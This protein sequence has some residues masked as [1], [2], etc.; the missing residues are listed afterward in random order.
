[1][2]S[3]LVNSI[4]DN[5]HELLE[6][7]KQN[8]GKFAIW[9]SRVIQSTLIFTGLLAVLLLAFS[10]IQSGNGIGK[11]IMAGMVLLMILGCTGLALG[12]ILPDRIRANLFCILLYLMG[13]ASLLYYGQVG[14]GQVL[15]FMLPLIAV[16]L[17][18]VESSLTFL[19][20]SVLT[21]LGF[22]FLA[23][24][25]VLDV[26]LHESGVRGS[27]S[28]W[29]LQNGSAIVI[30][31]IM[32]IS[33]LRLYHFLLQN[34]IEADQDA[35][36]NRQ[37]H[38]QVETM[39]GGVNQ[40]L[41][42]I[43]Q[44]ITQLDGAIRE[45]DENAVEVRDDLTHIATT[46]QQVTFGIN[47]QTDSVTSTAS[48]VEQ[49]S[50][51]V[52]VVS[53]G[54]L[55]QRSAVED[56]ST[57]AAEMVKIF[58]NIANN[59]RNVQ[60]EAKAAA[61]TAQSGTMTVEETIQS[62]QSIKDKTMQTAEIVASM[63]KQSERVSDILDTI[64]DIASQTNLLALNAA[65]E[66]ARAGEHG[67]GFAVVA[68]EV[69]KLADRS[70]QAT[71]QISRIID[72]IQQTVN[73]AV[74]SMNESTQEVEVGVT[75]A[76]LSGKA[77]FD[78]LESVESVYNHAGNTVSS[79]DSKLDTSRKLETAMQAVSDVVQKNITSSEI[80]KKNTSSMTQ[81]I[82]SIASV[83]EQNNAA[84]E[85]LTAA[86]QEIHQDLI[87]VTQAVQNLPQRI[88]SL[89]EQLQKINHTLT[90]N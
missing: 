31:L 45:L 13:L 66:A 78:I 8:T 4:K 84:M 38:R 46:L 10:F 40:T 2:V 49:V 62:M 89:V 72:A 18:N 30:M 56:A 24:G 52:E 41:T 26:F 19:A 69:R 42:A 17:I 39:I 6:Q 77:L 59:A 25:G 75:R 85:E 20:L 32:Y 9:R 90:L 27:L 1:M 22:P 28:G 3:S 81:S 16:L 65:I 51:A 54:T 11:L 48:S 76:N 88:Q 71:Q 36:A 14:F 50:Q 53:S 21:L 64:N 5:F 60:S 74:C 15:L 79:A 58:Q 68:D 80:M 12:K 83:S 87:N 82:E 55:E 44:E 61:T 86:T 63:G 57:I 70:A 35:T 7:D 67:K 34:L 33:L 43:N 47:Q 29:F 73:D 23:A 37:E